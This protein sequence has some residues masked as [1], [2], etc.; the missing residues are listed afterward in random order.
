MFLPL[1]KELGSHLPGSR[2]CLSPAGGTTAGAR[3]AV[4]AAK[5]VTSAYAD[6]V[7]AAGH[8][9]H[10]AIG[11]TA[12]HRLG[13]STTALW[14]WRDRHGTEAEWADVLAGRVL[15]DG[16][17]PWEIITGTETTEASPESAR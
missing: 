6:E 16:A 11:F 1:P 5:V 2:P 3:A 17:D 4:A 15:D 10:G 9:I 13:R 8:Q 12:E 14:T 7:A